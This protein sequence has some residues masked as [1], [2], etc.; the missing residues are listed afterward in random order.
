MGCRNDDK[1]NELCTE[2]DK[3][4]NAT[5]VRDECVLPAHYLE[6]PNSFD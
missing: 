2:C 6:C 5:R 4:V 3:S 1:G